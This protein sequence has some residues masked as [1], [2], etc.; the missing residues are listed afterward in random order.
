MG[1]VIP[2]RRSRKADPSQTAWDEYQALGKAAVDN[3]C[4][5]LDKDHCEAMSLAW[6]RWRS[7]FLGVRSQ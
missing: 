3:P 7:L 6:S 5:M 4:L 2:F 1:E